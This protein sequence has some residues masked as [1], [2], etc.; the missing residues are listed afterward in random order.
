[1]NYKNNCVLCGSMLTKGISSSS[2]YDG[3]SKFIN[4]FAGDG[5]YS[6]VDG[7][8]LPNLNYP[9]S[10]IANCNSCYDSK[11]LTRFI[12]PYGTVFLSDLIKTRYSILYHYTLN[13][14]EKTYKALAFR[15]YINLSCDEEIYQIDASLRFKESV[16][17]FGN[18]KNPIHMFK[19]ITLDNLDMT[20]ILNKEQ[21][22]EKCKFLA[23]LS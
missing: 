17:T 4:C 6:T 13:Y 23:S 21:F 8:T 22:L 10:V 9:I 14:E 7:I 3:R 15:E 2:D 12:P 16:F 18:K 19:S 11:N 5:T 1:M 20:S